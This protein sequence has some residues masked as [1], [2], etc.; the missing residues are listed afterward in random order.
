MAEEYEALIKQNTWTLVSPPPHANVIGW[1]W[2]YKIKRHS[3][4]TVAGYKARL[5]ANG[6]QQ[7]EGID[8]TE[9]FSPVIKHP[10]VW[11][12][13]SLAVQYKWHIRQL[14]VSNA[15]LHGMI[16][17]DVYMKQPLG[18]KNSTFPHYVCKLNK[19][20]YGLKQ[21]P[22]AWFSTFC[23]VFHSTWFHK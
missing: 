17:E 5:V 14:D 20:L 21:T 15:F 23:W 1:Q 8:Y 2:I 16:E 7:A 12:V 22:R 10:T 3:D 11:I 19:A 18:Y 6:N 4:G 9:T 13:L